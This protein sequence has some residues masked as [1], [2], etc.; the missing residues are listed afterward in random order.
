M[1]AIRYFWHT[2]LSERKSKQE[3]KNVNDGVETGFDF[4][5]IMIFWDSKINGS[6]HSR[7]LT[8]WKT[9]KQRRE[10]SNNLSK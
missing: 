2:K 3:E 1:I 6:E 7:V 9:L 10:K 8:T 4:K 5:D